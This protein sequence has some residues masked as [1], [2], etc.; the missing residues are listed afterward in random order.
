M[1]VQHNKLAYVTGSSRGVGQALVELLLKK[2]FH[3]IGLSRTNQLEAKNFTFIELDLSDLSKVKKFDFSMLAKQV[4]LV[5]NGGV[6]GEVAPVGDVSNESIE[7]TMKVNTLAPQ[8]LMNNFVKSFREQS[9]NFHILNISSGAG[10]RPVPSWATYCASK[11]A[12]DLFSETLA[13]ELQWEEKENWHVHSCAP[14]VVDTKMQD[15]IRSVSEA[16]FRDVERF[17]AL[18]TNN[19]L[20]SPQTVAEKLYQIIEHPEKF[21]EVII[22]VREL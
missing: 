7:K 2:G 14:G 13:E 10:K 6:L 8:I 1:T 17:K 4:I 18:K 12:L 3:V 19:E 20:L 16:K 11:A 22:S 21:K 9:G 5:N 15:E